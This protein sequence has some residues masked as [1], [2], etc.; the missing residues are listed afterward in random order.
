MTVIE[1]YKQIGGDYEN[2][3]NRFKNEALIKRFLPMFLNDPSFSELKDALENGDVQTAFRAAHTLKGVCANLSLAKLC[4]T[5]SEITE[6]L[7]AENLTEA[8]KIYPAVK[9]DYDAAFEAITQFK[10][11]MQ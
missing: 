7:R 10:N 2:A 5:A 4:D 3:I 1:C 6:L 8:K 9:A 11:E